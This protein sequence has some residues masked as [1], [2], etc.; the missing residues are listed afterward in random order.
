MHA[1]QAGLPWLGRAGG[2]FDSNACRQGSESDTSAGGRC[3]AAMLRQ[4]HGICG[5]AI[6]RHMQRVWPCL[7]ALTA[8]NTQGLHAPG[9]EAGTSEARVRVE[10][11]AQQV[12]DCDPPVREK[13]GGGEAEGFGWGWCPSYTPSCCRCS[14]RR[15]RLRRRCPSRRCCPLPQ[16]RLASPAAVALAQGGADE[17]AGVQQAVHVHP[18]LDATAVAEHGVVVQNG[19]QS[20]AAQQAGV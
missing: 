5:A 7:H 10:G 3:L 20:M 18:S 12:A 2:A 8:G 17:L 15:A 11:Y 6:S 16:Q 13:E 1:L 9:G 19:R 14:S 4:C